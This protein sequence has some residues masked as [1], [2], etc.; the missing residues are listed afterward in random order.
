MSIGGPHEVL[1]PHGFNPTRDLVLALR[2]VLGSRAGRNG[3]FVVDASG[4]LPAWRWAGASQG[5]TG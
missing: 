3:T 1:P 2:E 4:E 5:S